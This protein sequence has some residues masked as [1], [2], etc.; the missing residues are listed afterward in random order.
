MLVLS[1]KTSERI[2]LGKD[3]VVTVVA[4]QGG[5]V[6]LGIEAPATVTVRR[7]E[8]VGPG[9]ALEGGRLGKALPGR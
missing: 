1:R 9:T 6:R 5:R 3:V 4:V 8:L 7:Q 2:V